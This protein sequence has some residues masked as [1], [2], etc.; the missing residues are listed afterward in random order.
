M[1]LNFLLSNGMEPAAHNTP[2]RAKDHWGVDWG[3]RELPLSDANTH[4][5]THI[6]TYTQTTVHAPQYKLYRVS[7]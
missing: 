4:T 2:D 6:H 1:N 5:H 3:E 7:G